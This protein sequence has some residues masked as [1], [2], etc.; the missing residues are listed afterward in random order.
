MDREALVGLRCPG[1]NRDALTVGR[2]VSQD[3][4][5]RGSRDEERD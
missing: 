2:T 4:P 5:G 1:I 3:A